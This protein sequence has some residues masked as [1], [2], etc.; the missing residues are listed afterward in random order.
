LSNADILS[1]RDKHASYT[2]SIEDGILCAVIK[3]AVGEAISQKYNRDFRQLITQLNRPV[4]GHYSDMR[5]CEGL[6]Q[7]AKLASVELHDYAKQHGCVVT[8]F[9]LDLAMLRS[10]VNDIRQNVNLGSLDAQNIFT[11][12]QACMDYLKAYLAKHSSSLSG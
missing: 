7:E 6:T 9:Q 4:W 1:G 3:G 11:T 5:E 10:Q 8:A 2:L 12:K